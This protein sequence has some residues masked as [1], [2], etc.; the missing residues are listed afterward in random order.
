MASRAG[1][2]DEETWGYG[3]GNGSKMAKREGKIW[4]VRAQVEANPS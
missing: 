4:R 3:K 1:P 2:R